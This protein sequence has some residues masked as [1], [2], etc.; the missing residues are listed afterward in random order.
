MLM[1]PVSRGS[2]KASRAVRG[3]SGSSSK[4]NTPW[5]ASEIS[6]GRGGTPPP[7]KATALAVW[8]GLRT[9]RA[10]QVSS[11]K[12]PVRLARAALCKASCVSMGGKS[13]AK[14]CANIDLPDPGGPLS[15]T[16]WP[17]AAAISR[18]RLA[19]AWPLTSDKSPSGALVLWVVGANRV[20]PFG[21]KAEF[22]LGLGFEWAL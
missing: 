16:W 8:C 19:A 21:V 17:P 5:C 7:T 2:R 6:P 12:V 20:Q 13:P 14:R 10:P 3:N 4:N 18:A 11:F 15:N 22:E 9:G 1:C